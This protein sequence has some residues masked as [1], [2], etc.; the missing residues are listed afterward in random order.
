MAPAAA[1][2]EVLDNCMDHTPIGESAAAGRST[3]GVAT[4]SLFW[5]EG[6]SPTMPLKSASTVKVSRQTSPLRLVHSEP[7]VRP[8]RDLSPGQREALNQLIG[9]GATLD[10]SFTMQELRSQFRA[11]ARAYHPDRHQGTL[12]TST[13]QLARSFVALRRAY[14]VL[15]QAA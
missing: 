9:L 6:A 8:A 10:A 1:F 5:F 7:P 13:E 3:S 2:A 12:R 4:R 11:L 15:K 14:D